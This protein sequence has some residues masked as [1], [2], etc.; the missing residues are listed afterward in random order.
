MERADVLMCS[1]TIVL[2]KLEMENPSKLIR[3]LISL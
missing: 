1:L 2:T 3:L